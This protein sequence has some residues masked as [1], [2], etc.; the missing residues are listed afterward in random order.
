[1]GLVAVALCNEDNSPMF[2][3]AAEHDAVV[4]ELLAKK[5]NPA[6]QAMIEGCLAI[7]GMKKDAMKDAVG[8]SDGNPSDSLS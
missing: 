1:M 3:D 6:V 8:N 7:Q 4:E 5:S 2:P